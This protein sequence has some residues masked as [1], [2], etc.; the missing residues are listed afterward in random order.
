M[1]YNTTEIFVLDEVQFDIGW[2]K[3]IEVNNCGIY[4]IR[5]EKIYL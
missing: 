4:M 1:R 5:S 3:L 2:T